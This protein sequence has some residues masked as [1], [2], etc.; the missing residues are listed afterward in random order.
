M[1]MWH[2]TPLVP[3][4]CPASQADDVHAYGLILQQLCG[5]LSRTASSGAQPQ[6]EAEPVTQHKHAGLTYAKMQAPCIDMLESSASG[7]ESEHHELSV[8]QPPDGQLPCSFPPALAWLLFACLAHEPTERPSFG[9]IMQ[10]L[11]GVVRAEGREG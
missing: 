9:C 7:I 1:Q 8:P 10:T 4:A 3:P 6:A 5:G 2:F 11:E